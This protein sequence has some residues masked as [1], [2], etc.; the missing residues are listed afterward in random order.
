LGAHATREVT[1]C[2]PLGDLNYVKNFNGVKQRR[3]KNS[4]TM[5]KVYII[6]KG[7]HDYS[8]AEK[9]GDITYLS[10]G[11]LSRFSTGKMYRMFSDTLRDSDPGDHLLISGMTI[12]SV[13]AVSIF[14]HKHGRINLLLYNSGPNKKNDYVS[15]TLVLED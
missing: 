7:C 14:A 2:E 15:R 10:D 3:Y 11:I 4:E 12:M 6:N 9:F 1:G 13:V 8:A 5:P